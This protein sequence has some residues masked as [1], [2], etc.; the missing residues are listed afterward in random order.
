MFAFAARY[1]SFNGE[2]TK[3]TTN[4]IYKH[5]G[6]SCHRERLIVEKDKR[7]VISLLMRETERR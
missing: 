4:D 1:I 3:E 7:S 6:T 5:P 2:Y